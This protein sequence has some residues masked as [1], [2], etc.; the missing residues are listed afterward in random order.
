MSER[1]L[2][3]RLSRLESEVQHLRDQ[4]EIYGEVQILRDKQEIYDVLMK[5]CRGVDRCDTELID[6]VQRLD[7][8]YP[9]YR[10]Y[11]EGKGIVKIVKA[12]AKQTTHFIGN[13]LIEVDGDTAKSESYFF[14][15]H[16]VG[17]AD[18]DYVRTVCARYLH[19]FARLDG[20]WFVTS[21]YVA[22]DWSRFDEIKELA[23]GA[24][25]WV[26]GER[27]REDASYKW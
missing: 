27:S 1:T 22:H 12:E 8:A 15:L 4:Q 23:P 9:T 2:A 19:H 18:H 11:Y 10:S 21:K 26:P 5:Y 6:S 17:R 20:R 25:T 16:V 24:D 14:S 3:D 13:V 7:P